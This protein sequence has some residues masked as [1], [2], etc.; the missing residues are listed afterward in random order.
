MSLQRHQQYYPVFSAVN[1]VKE[2]TRLQPFGNGRFQSLISQRQLSAIFSQFTDI[3][4][5][6]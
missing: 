4:K 1:L 5:G 2:D 6:T 3:G